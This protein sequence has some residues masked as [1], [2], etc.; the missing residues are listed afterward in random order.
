MYGTDDTWYPERVRTFL[1]A[2]CD[3]E[4]A[5][6]QGWFEEPGVND[7]KAQFDLAARGFVSCSCTT[8]CIP[9]GSDITSHAAA[10][11]YIKHDP[12]SQP[13]YTEGRRAL[14]LVRR[15]WAC[16][17]DDSGTYGGLC[18]YNGL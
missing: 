1:D 5:A 6:S 11:K 7:L 8:T 3:P 12:Q 10:R 13:S 18:E 14:H 9:A 16:D 4:A 2:P 15:V 17:M